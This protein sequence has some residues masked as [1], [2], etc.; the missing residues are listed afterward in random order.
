M[1]SYSF[2]IPA[3]TAG[4]HRVAAEDT[5]GNLANATFEV[6]PWLSLSVSSGAAG[7]TVTASGT[8]FG[9]RAAISIDFAGHQVASGRTNEYGSF[10]VAFAVPQVRPG[11]LHL[12]ALD[13]E[14]NSASAEFTISVGA[15]MDTAS[16]HVGAD[17]TVK[18]SGFTPGAMASVSYDGMEVARGAVDNNGVFSIVFKVPPSSGGRHVVAISDGVNRRELGFT[19]ESVPP[20]VPRLL[21]PTEGTETRP[22]TYFDWESVS[23]PS[24]PVTYT[25]Q[26]AADQNFASVVLEKERI[27]ASEYTLREEESLTAYAKTTT[28]YWRVKATDAAFNESEWSPSSS[29]YVAPPPAPLLLLPEPEV[30]VPGLIRFDW[31]DIVGLSPPVTY[32][33]QIASDPQFSSIVLEKGGLTRSE[34]M[35]TEEEMDTFKG[36]GPYY[37]RVKVVDSTASESNWSEPQPFHAGTESGLP[38]W[39]VYMLIGFGLVILGLLAFWLGRRTAY[40]QG[41]L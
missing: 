29:F 8:G 28:Y 12:R 39:A 31:E 18:G 32:T 27:G 36:A 11:T 20:L 30:R 26:V 38:A 21:L 33:L 17:V 10:E 14:G 41:I 37:W 7:H 24:M 16:G 5:H 2:A 19:V 15:S 40:Y 1:C 13:T 3:S 4:I 22:Q 6:L 34:Y 35:L 23:D 25:L 9:Y